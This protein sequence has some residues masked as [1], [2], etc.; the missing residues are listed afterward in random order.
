M[1]ESPTYYS[2]CLTIDPTPIYRVEFATGSTNGGD[3]Q[4]F[5]ASDTAL[6]AIAAARLSINPKS[7]TEPFA[8][9]CTDLSLPRTIWRPMERKSSWLGET[10]SGSIRILT[11]PGM[12]PVDAKFE[13][14]VGVMAEPFFQLWWDGPLPLVPK[15]RFMHDQRG[16]EYIFCTMARKVSEKEV[17]LIEIRRGGGLE[18]ELTV[19]LQ[20]FA[21]LRYQKK[22]LV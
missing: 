10:Y 19:L 18:F 4:I 16:P 22:P 14:E 11:V 21:I 3:I 7:K 1:R 5:P 8:R 13:W 6:P 17:N 2:V 12:A 20:L 9:I 15:S